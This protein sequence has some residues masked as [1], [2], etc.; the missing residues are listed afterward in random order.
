MFLNVAEY[1]LKTLSGSKCGTEGTLNVAASMPSVE[2]AVIATCAV[3]STRGPD[4]RLSCRCLPL[5]QRSPRA[6]GC[7]GQV[8]LSLVDATNLAV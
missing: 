4:P 6:V 3:T 8:L 5:H 2:S 7:G 1:V